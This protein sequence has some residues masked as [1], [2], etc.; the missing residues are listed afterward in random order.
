ME[1]GVRKILGSFFSAQKSVRA[2]NKITSRLPDS[3]QYNLLED[4]NR[5]LQ[6]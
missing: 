2:V 4:E 6:K 3:V 1:E 5:Y